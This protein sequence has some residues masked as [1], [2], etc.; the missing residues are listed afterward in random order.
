MA[1]RPIVQLKD[2][3]PLESAVKPNIDKITTRS[4]TGL[5]HPV[6]VGVRPG[7][8]IAHLSLFG[9]PIDIYYPGRGPFEAAGYGLEVK[10]GDV[11]LR[12]NF[13]TV[14]N[15]LIVGSKSKFIIL[16]LKLDT[17]FSAPLEYFEIFTERMTFCRLAANYLGYKFSLEINKFKL[18]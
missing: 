10:I 3:T 9:Y 13:A 5:M 8:D 4:V 14:D 7:S 11:A 16:R 15:D 6:D 18:L 1:D 17:K 2:K 12:G